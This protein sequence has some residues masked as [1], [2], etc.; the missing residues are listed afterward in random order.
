MQNAS[1]E[2]TNPSHCK[3][4]LTKLCLVNTRYEKQFSRIKSSKPHSE[5][6]LG[7]VDQLKL[8]ISQ[9]EKTLSNVKMERDLAL[10]DNRYRINEIKSSIFAIKRRVNKLVENKASHKKHKKGTKSRK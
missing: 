5:K 4:F 3:E 9:L 6:E 8:K 7:Q 1:L 10:E 2:N